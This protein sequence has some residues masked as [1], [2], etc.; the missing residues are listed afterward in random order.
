[1][2]GHNAE[3]EEPTRRPGPAFVPRLWLHAERLL[4]D[5]GTGAFAE[6][7]TAVLSLRFAYPSSTVRP[8]DDPLAAPE[9]RRYGAVESRAQ[10]LLEG[11]G[12]VEIGYL[13]HVI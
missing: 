9:F 7:E 11:F 1:M 12:A 2:R 5:P 4:I 6:Q 13:E 8:T 10:F 3:I